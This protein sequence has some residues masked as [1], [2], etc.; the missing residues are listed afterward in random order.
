MRKYWRVENVRKMTLSTGVAGGR[1]NKDRLDWF[2]NL[3]LM[4]KETFTNDDDLDT[5]TDQF[6]FLVQVEKVTSYCY[7]SC[8]IMF[9]V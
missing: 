2:Q 6:V 3:F 1:N 5:I 7:C 9:S 8:F 4:L